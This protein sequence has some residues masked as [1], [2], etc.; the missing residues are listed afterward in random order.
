MD[1][2]IYQRLKDQLRRNEEGWY[3]TN[4][5]YKQF[6]PVLPSNKTRGLG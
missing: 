3:E 6:S 4:I 1:N 5:L 2:Y